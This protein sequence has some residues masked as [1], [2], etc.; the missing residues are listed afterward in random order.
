MI[1]TG[2]QPNYMPYPG[3]FEK[4]ARS[5][6]FLIVD[7][8]Q[9]VKRGPFGWIH[10]N[11]IRTEGGDG[12]SWLTIPVLTKGKFH[13]SIRETAIDN[14]SSWGKKHWKTIEW[15]YRKASYYSEYASDIVAIYDQ[16]W[17]WLIDLTEEWIRV[18]LGWLGLEREMK[19]TSDLNVDG[20]ATDMVVDMCRKVGADGY[21]SGMHGKDYLE[22]ESFQK[23]GINLLFQDYSCPEYPQCGSGPFVPNLSIV[24]MF[25]NC[26]P[27]SRQLLMGGNG[28]EA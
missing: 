22:V 24:D 25:L 26:G 7:H 10:R 18:I 28:F 17:D 15:N 23:A 20:K 1:L 5:D 2:H 4:I 3:F 11:R 12:W 8:V 13:Q 19:R 21:L 6:Q 16:K 9:F 27:G 14:A